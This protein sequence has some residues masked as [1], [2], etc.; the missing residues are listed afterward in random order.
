MGR[1]TRTWAAATAG[2]LLAPVLLGI[3]LALASCANSRACPG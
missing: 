3:C 2:G 1:P